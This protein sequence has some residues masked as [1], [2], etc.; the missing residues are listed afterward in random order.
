[1]APIIAEM[2]PDGRLETHEELGHF[3][4]LEE[5]AAMARSVLDLMR[6]LPR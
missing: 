1:M 2:L 4:P 6:T 3:G 5:P